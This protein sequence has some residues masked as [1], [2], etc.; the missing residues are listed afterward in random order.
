MIGA[1]ATGKTH[2]ITQ[3]FCNQDVDILNVYDY[4]RKAYDEAGFDK[5]IPVD[6]RVECLYKAN[7]MHL[8]DIIDRLLQGRNVVAEQTFFKAKRRIAYIDEIRQ[9]TDAE[10]EIYVMTPTDKQWDQ[11]IKKRELSD[12]LSDLKLQLQEFE[13]PNPS[14]GFD[15]I[16]EVINGEVHLRMD[17]EKPEILE[18]ARKEFL[19]EAERIR[20]IRLKGK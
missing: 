18:Q 10:I 4:Q 19:E 7:Q 5:Y 2:F 16:Y 12:N 8:S 20:R 15:A 9:R 3:Q 1:N 6:V 13:F 11:N 14:E 17:Q